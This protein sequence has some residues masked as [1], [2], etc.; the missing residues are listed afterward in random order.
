MR[1]PI[2]TK[3][4]FEGGNIWNDTNQKEVTKQALSGLFLAI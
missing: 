1:T 2:P 3:I 4:A